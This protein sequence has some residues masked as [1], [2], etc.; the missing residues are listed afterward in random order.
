ML[1]SKQIDMNEIDNESMMKAFKRPTNIK[2]EIKKA[3]PII[4]GENLE[5]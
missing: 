5:R 1:H 4:K 3:K 2:G